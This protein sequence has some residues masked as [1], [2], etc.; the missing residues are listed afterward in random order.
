MLHLFGSL[1][2][3]TRGLQVLSISDA[4]F[5]WSRD[6]TLP[7]T[8]EGITMSVKKGELVGILGRVGAGKVSWITG[9]ASP[10]ILI[11]Y[12]RQAFSQL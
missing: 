3:L 5:S 9:N 7:P 1:T 10:I 11:P 6:L 12:V 2:I 8:L 4:D